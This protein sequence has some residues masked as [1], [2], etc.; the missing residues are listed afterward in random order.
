M[1]TGAE[2]EYPGTDLMEIR[3]PDGLGSIADLGLTLSEVKLL[4]ASVRREMATAQARVHVI[5][6]L[7]WVPLLKGT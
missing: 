4:L 3:R 7:D 6:R 5:M 2:G 1:K